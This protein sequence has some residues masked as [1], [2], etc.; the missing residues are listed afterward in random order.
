MDPENISF[1]L[2]SSNRLKINKKE[3]LDF[4]INRST[5]FIR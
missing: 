5:D 2:N 1:Q 3:E 4:M